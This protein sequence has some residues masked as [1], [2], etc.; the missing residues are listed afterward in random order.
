[1]HM[2][3]THL[4]EPVVSVH[5]WVFLSLDGA[6]AVAEVPTAGVCPDA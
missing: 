3:T 6:Q 4:Q 2:H 1:M 5:F